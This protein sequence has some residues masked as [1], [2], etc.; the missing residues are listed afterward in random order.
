MRTGDLSGG[1]APAL[2]RGLAIIELVAEASE[3]IAFNALLEQTDTPRATLVRLLKVLVQRG[4]LAK[5][6]RSGRYMPGAM[7]AM[8]RPQDALKARLKVIASPVLS[9]L[10]DTCGNTVTLFYRQ[11][12]AFECFIKELHQDGLAMQPIGTL[13]P[14]LYS[15]PWGWALLAFLPV[16]FIEA[17]AKAH[18]DKLSVFIGRPNSLVEFLQQR[19]AEFNARG[20]AFDDQLS[21]EGLRRMGV[22]VRDRSGNVIAALGMAGTPQS[23]NDE[24]VD[25]IGKRMQEAARQLE[26]HLGV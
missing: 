9:S 20:F 24:D 12:D 1:P 7:L 15:P 18:E 4:Y 19:L 22:P 11:G 5:E 13:N 23:M 26:S 14:D 3:P 21:R 16:T 17:Y 2:S 25:T 6:S 10:R 8:L